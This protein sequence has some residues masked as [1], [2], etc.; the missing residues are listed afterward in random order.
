MIYD[1]TGKISGKDFPYSD[2]CVLIFRTDCGNVTVNFDPGISREESARALASMAEGLRA[3]E[4][5]TNVS[6]DEAG[7][8]NIPADIAAGSAANFSAEVAQNDVSP[9]DFSGE[10]ER[11]TARKSVN[12][13]DVTEDFV[14]WRDGYSA[15][16]LGGRWWWIRWHDAENERWGMSG[17]L[18]GAVDVKK[19]PFD[20]FDETLASMM[21]HRAEVFRKN[22]YIG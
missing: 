6:A 11:E 7:A 12:P 2:G 14:R 22:S 9:A 8:K 20:N 10:I 18:M 3:A 19:G 21:R 16:K 4:D 1:V 13:D 5:P 17:P 15:Y